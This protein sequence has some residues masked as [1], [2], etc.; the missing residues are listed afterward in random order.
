M[1]ELLE[2]ESLKKVVSGIDSLPSLPALYIELVKE[3][4]SEDA[5]IQKVGD[6]ISKDLGLITKVLKLVNSFFFGVPQRI[7]N[8]AKAVSLLG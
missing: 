7:T 8:T 3:L 6:I 5:S 4:K 2:Q 1:K